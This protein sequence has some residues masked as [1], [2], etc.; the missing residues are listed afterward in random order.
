MS[1]SVLNCIIKPQKSQYAKAKFY[2]IRVYFMKNNFL[3]NSSVGKTLYD[4]INNLPI[5]D[6]HNHLSLKDLKKNTRF[7]DIYDLWIAPDP[8]KHRAM[9][10]CGV[11]EKYITGDC[12]KKEKF[13]K[14]CETIPKIVGG[15]LYHWSHMEI[16]FL[17][18]S[19]DFS[20]SDESLFEKCNSYLA[21][22]IVTPEV[23]LKRFNV[24]YNCPC[25]SLL[26]DIIFCEEKDGLAPSLRGDDIVNLSPEFIKKLSKII[27]VV[28]IESSLFFIT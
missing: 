15:P 3:L 14:W 2:Q 26:D 17:L 10:M 18:D 24:E 9:R 16:E 8:Y 22:N 19:D 6:Y 5:I 1:L 25:A 7:T 21:E 20:W 4:R 11:E 27:C 23:L 28:E 13:L 12:D